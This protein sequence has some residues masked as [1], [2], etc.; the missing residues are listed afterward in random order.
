MGKPKLAEAIDQLK[1][2]QKEYQKMQ[3]TDGVT[4]AQLD[5]FESKISAQEKLIVDLQ[6]QEQS[7]KK[8]DLPKG[9]F[10]ALKKSLIEIAPQ[11]KGKDNKFFPEPKFVAAV[12][13]LQPDDCEVASSNGDVYVVHA[14]KFGV[15]KVTL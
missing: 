11:V 2:L 5:E 7:A 3:S 14:G 8:G 10:A 9:L 15:R 13:A 4:E 12:N 1:A 6:E